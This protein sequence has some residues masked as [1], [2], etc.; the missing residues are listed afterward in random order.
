[1]SPAGGESVE[2]DCDFPIRRRVRTDKR[3]SP[4]TFASVRDCLF[5]Q[6]KCSSGGSHTILKVDELTAARKYAKKK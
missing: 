2:S 3:T 4:A 6:I 1:L 5:C